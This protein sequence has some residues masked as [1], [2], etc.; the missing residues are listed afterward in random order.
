MNMHHGCC[1]NVRYVH[2]LSPKGER[3][4]VTYFL[5]VQFPETSIGIK[6][7]LKQLFKQSRLTKKKY[8][9]AKH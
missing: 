6:T 4:M 5:M 7:S 9:A 3:D 2:V 8:A 1:C